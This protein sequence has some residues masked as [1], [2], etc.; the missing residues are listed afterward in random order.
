MIGLPLA[1]IA[2]WTWFSVPGDPWLP[3][4]RNG[5]QPWIAVPGW[6]SLSYELA[7]HSL[8]VWAM[9]DVGWDIAKNV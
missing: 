1:T 7:I 8:A 9:H 4:G 3:G 6:V 5:T 2:T